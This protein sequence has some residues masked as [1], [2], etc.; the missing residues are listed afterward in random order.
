MNVRCG[1][2]LVIYVASISKMSFPVSYRKYFSLALLL[3]VCYYWGLSRPGHLLEDNELVIRKINV[4]SKNKFKACHTE[5]W[6]PNGHVKEIYNK[7]V[8]TCPDNDLYANNWGPWLD[9]ENVTFFQKKLEE[10]AQF[11]HLQLELI[12]NGTL[13]ASEVRT[14][15]W[16]CPDGVY[17]AGL[18][19]QLH[20]IE[21]AFLLAV[22]SNRVFGIYWDPITMETMKYLEPHAIRWDLI[23]CIVESTPSELHGKRLRTKKEYSRLKSAIYSTDK[24]HVTLTMETFVYVPKAL[25]YLC[26]KDRKTTKLFQ[27]IGLLQN[28]TVYNFPMDVLNS[29]IMHYLFTFQ[30]QL[31]DTVNQI[32]SREGLTVP[33]VGVHLRTGFLGNEYEEKE[34]NLTTSEVKM[35]R[36]KNEWYMSIKC[37][38]YLAK[39][40]FGNNSLI[41]LATDSYEVKKMAK[42]MFPER[43]RTLNIGLEH[44]GMEKIKGN[45]TYKNKYLVSQNYHRNSENMSLI[46]DSG[47]NS[48]LVQD[49]GAL[50]RKLGMWIDF[51]LLARSYAMVWTYS[52]F[53]G[54]A[55][56]VCLIPQSK[57]FMTPY[58]ERRQ[59]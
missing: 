5:N 35:D 47:T 32:Q 1:A 50:G 23:H 49:S 51:L 28:A 30:S 12:R 17:C 48:S 8:T 31:V 24:A 46:R 41:F 36:H 45:P 39:M 4:A 37:S 42:A 56:N 18:G 9:N 25:L 53:S 14:L 26:K 33:Y 34:R 29:V 40:M 59:Q 3:F 22:I 19:D 10:Y 38:I 13:S 43:I 57:A 54:S 6:S 55:S 7:F 11:H 20:R 58:C 27:R 15:T 2:R 52:G 16:S 21:V 44:M